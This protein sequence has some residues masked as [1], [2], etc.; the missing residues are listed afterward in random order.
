MPET[1]EPP[2]SRLYWLW[3]VQ[4]ETNSILEYKLV[5]DLFYRTTS[6]I[7]HFTNCPLNCFNSNEISSRHQILI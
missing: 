5:T 3:Q 6:K 2:F 4:L 7:I 1:Q